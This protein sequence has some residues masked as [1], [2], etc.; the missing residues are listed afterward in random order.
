[1]KSG[2]LS[3]VYYLTSWRQPPPASQCNLPIARGCSC[4]T[5]TFIG[6]SESLVPKVLLGLAEHP[7]NV[8]VQKKGL[9]ERWTIYLLK[10]PLDL[11]SYLWLCEE[12]VVLKYLWKHHL[13]L[14]FLACC[15]LRIS[16]Y[17]S[18]YTYSPT[19][20]HFGSWKKTRYVKIS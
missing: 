7:W 13:Y 16:G 17:E 4:I 3:R 18:V 14:I 15:R 2:P 11:K 1:M 19:Y 20:A 12:A 9:K 10:A 6:V 8:G 5:T